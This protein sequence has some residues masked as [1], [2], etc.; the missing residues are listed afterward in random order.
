M[1]HKNELALLRDHQLAKLRER[2]GKPVRLI[3]PLACGVHDREFLGTFSRYSPDQKFK[4][5]S[6]EP[7]KKAPI[8]DRLKALLKGKRAETAPA[9]DVLLDDV[10]CPRCGTLDV[11][12]L[13]YRCNSFVCN[14]R[15][16]ASGYYECRDSCGGRGTT[17]PLV[18]IDGASGG[19]SSS[20]IAIGHSSVKRLTKG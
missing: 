9:D 6:I 10:A 11:W 17:K 7:V 5:E 12:T 13:C 2:T 18:T 16:A 19:G 20:P 3:L 14:G 1:S 4:C 15:R 8:I